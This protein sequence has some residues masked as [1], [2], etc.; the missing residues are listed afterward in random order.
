[1]KK[2]AAPPCP[3]RPNLCAAL[4]GKDR[5]PWLTSLRPHH[6]PPFDP[7]RRPP[8]IA[9]WLVGLHAQP[10]FQ[11]KEESHEPAEGFYFRDA[12]EFTVKSIALRNDYGEPVEEFEV[13]FIE[14]DLIDCDLAKAIDLHQGSIS[15]FLSC[16]AEWE[17][18]EKI[19]VIVAVGECGYSFDKNSTPDCF[20]VDIYRV[21]TMRDLAKQFVDDG[22]FGEIPEHLANYIDLD[23]IARDLTADYSETKIAGERLIYR[24]G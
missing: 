1:M 18:D 10:V 15:N 22:L 8:L 6:L 19:A 3:S 7:D 24:C 9:A 16:A 23:A 20:E 21:A 13:Q 2:G 5:R 11:R 14:G 4:R 17:E 12:D